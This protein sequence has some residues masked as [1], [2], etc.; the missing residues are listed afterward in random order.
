MGLKSFLTGFDGC[1]DGAEL[2]FRSDP[3]PPSASVPRSSHLKSTWPVGQHF[4]VD[5][6]FRTNSPPFASSRHDN[7][8]TARSKF[9]SLQR[10]ACQHQAVMETVKLRKRKERRTNVMRFPG[11]HCTRTSK[12]SQ[13][14]MVVHVSSSNNCP[15]TSQYP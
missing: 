12:V 8:M 15:L 2:P 10:I 3:G 1:T 9:P 4:D 6:T 13:Q 14:T 11:G 5:D 7:R